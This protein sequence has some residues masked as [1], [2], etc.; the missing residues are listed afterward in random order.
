MKIGIGI[1]MFNEHI[2]VLQT[3]KNIIKCKD[4]VPYIVV[5]HSDDANPSPELEEVKKLADEY[6]L[7]P[8]LG[9]ELESQRLGANCIS[10]NYGLIF[11]TLNKKEFDVVV[12]LTGDTLVTDPKNFIRR[13]SELEEGKVAY[14][15]Q[16]IGQ[17]FHTPNGPD[18]GRLQHQDITDM[19]PQLFILNGKFAYNTNCFSTIEV[20]NE[21][22]SEHCLG[23]ELASHVGGDF[24][25]KVQRLNALNPTQAYSYGDGISY[26]RRTLK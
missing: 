22:T 26:N 15:A 5:A 7:L 23:N 13:S 8:N 2:V 9:K 3:I 1:T 4:F 25:Q 19:M 12:G 14:I 10:R 17:K 6:T 16:A 21:Y 24:R 20:V 11:T 18:G